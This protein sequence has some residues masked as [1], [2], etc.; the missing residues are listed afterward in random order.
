[1]R[2]FCSFLFFP[3]SRDGVFS[4]NMHFSL[5]CSEVEKLVDIEQQ[6]EAQKQI[7]SDLNSRIRD[8]NAKFQSDLEKKEKEAEAHRRQMIDMRT[9]LQ[10]AEEVARSM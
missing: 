4:D 10:K 3:A 5:E 6:L 7:A 2:L 9:S 1:V 8:M